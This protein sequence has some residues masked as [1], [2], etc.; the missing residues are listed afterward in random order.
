M[1]SSALQKLHSFHRELNAHALEGARHFTGLNIQ[2]I[3]EYSQRFQQSLPQNFEHTDASYLLKQ[4]G[5]A[6][7]LL[8]G[9]FH[10]LKQ[11]QRGFLRLLC[12][13][14]DQ[15]PKRPLMVALEIFNASDQALIDDYQ[16]GKISESYFLKKI[17]YHNKWGFPWENYQPIVDYCI[18]SQ[19]RIHGINSQFESPN[20]LVRRDE[21]A[22]DLLNSWSRE[23]PDQLSLCLIGEHHLADRHL[24][25]LINP[26]YRTIRVVA[27][28]DE[29]AL[30]TLRLPLA[31]SE[32]LQLAQDFFCVINTAPWLKWQSLSMWEELHANIEGGPLVDEG[33]LYTEHHYDFDYQ[34]LHISKALNE[35]LGL[36]ISSSD[37][38]QFDLYVRPDRGTIN[39]LRSKL[40]LG[41]FELTALEES[42]QA[43]GFY[44]VSPARAILI[45]DASLCHFAEASG[46]FLYDTL[47]G[48]PLNGNEPSL[49][50]RVER[51]VCSTVATLL[52]NPRHPTLKAGELEHFTAQMRR[53]RL[54]GPSRTQRE[55]YR[56]I[57]TLYESLLGP[58]NR[59]KSLNKAPLVEKDR[60]SSFALSRQLGEMIGSALF[61]QVLLLDEARMLESLQLV[62]RG[63]LVEQT[64]LL[65]E[66]QEQG[67]NYPLSAS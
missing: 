42:L 17:D 66:L 8:F 64:S 46:H 44:Y 53:K 58:I 59:L 40:N 34:L 43:A 37:L 12:Q 18:R 41:P 25:N 6:R 19:I 62:F 32:Y 49:G 67:P 27:N 30:Q 11:S 60:R 14:R 55:I 23:Y 26:S 22:A 1:S 50:E 9:D 48:L 7:I 15:Y 39:H 36:G 47:R 63:K 33:D 2:E 16:S 61:Q 35:F 28:V 45:Q 38:T 54:L 21:F 20:R 4:V 5:D 31:S 3:A 13:I 51:H 10:T 57:K 24:L 65:R 29:Y 56:T 52:M